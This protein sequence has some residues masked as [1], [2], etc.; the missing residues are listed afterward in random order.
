MRKS[1]RTPMAVVIK[2]RTVYLPMQIELNMLEQL[3]LKSSVMYS[4]II[5]AAV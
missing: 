4:S 2:N 3:S 1:E 5:E